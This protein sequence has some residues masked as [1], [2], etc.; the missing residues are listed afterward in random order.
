NFKVDATG[1]LT[2]AGQQAYLTTHG[3]LTTNNSGG[4]AT[5]TLKELFNL[6]GDGKSLGNGGNATVT[7]DNNTYNFK[8]AA[9]LTDGAGVISAAGVTY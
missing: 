7:L 5:A 6:A 3:N 8:S 4:A 9:N 2:I 1:K